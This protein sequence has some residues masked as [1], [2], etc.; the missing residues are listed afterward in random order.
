[1]QKN[2]FEISLTEFTFILSKIG[3]ENDLI[4]WLQNPLWWATLI[5]N[6]MIVSGI[7]LKE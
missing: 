5:L 2:N 6:A 7:L 4:G 1:M 3:N